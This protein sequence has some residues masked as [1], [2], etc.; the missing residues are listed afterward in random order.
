MKPF[1]IVAATAQELPPLP[2][3]SDFESRILG[4]GMVNTA[5]KLTRWLEQEKPKGMIM[6]GI[7]GSY[8]SDLP[9]GSLVEVHKEIYAE[10]G[11]NTPEGFLDMQSLNLPLGLMG[12]EQIYNIWENPF[13]VITELPQVTGATIFRISGEMNA[14]SEMKK[15]WN[16]DIESMEGAAFFQIA[17]EYNVPFAQIRSVSNW[18]EPRDR[19]RWNIPL[20]LSTLH[21]FWMENHRDLV[22]QWK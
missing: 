9:L 8:L 16:P 3:S 21:Q 18:V 22:A 19:S 5:S 15:I 14:I 4:I 20:A 13:P 10:A 11:A 1:W 12:E 6:T 2:E 17:T 7:C